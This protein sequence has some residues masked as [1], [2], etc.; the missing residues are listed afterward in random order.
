[1]A[2]STVA[3]RYAKAFLELA[4]DV[5]EVDRLG[6]DLSTM[7]AVSNIEN[8]LVTQVLA[9]PVFT[10]E[11]RLTVLDAILP[12]LNL[13]QLT[14]NLLHL[15]VERG[16]FAALPAIAE[17]YA[18]AADEAAG[19]MRVRVETA[20][21]LTPQLEAEIKAA[22]E[23]TT[24]REVLIDPVVEPALIG[25]MVARVGSKVY[26]SSLRTR[27]QQIKQEL[28]NARVPAEA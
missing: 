1:M 25:G 7:L 14:S 9:N 15:L 5:G 11:E 20:E 27:L 26:D 17:L 10:R 21:P 3:R 13:H 19:R 4:Q 8:G 2:N 6:K 12:K 16:K 18:S 23:K 28:M 22:L 24:G